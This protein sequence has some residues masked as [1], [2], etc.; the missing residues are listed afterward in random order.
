[1]G[2]DIDPDN[3]ISFYHLLCNDDRYK[4][5]EDLKD[6]RDQETME[7]LKDYLN[8]FVTVQ[9]DLE[10]YE[11]YG[12]T[13]YYDKHR[14]VEAKKNRMVIY[15]SGQWITDDYNNKGERYTFTTSIVVSKHQEKGE[16]G[17][18]PSQNQYTPSPSNFNDESLNEYTVNRPPEEPQQWDSDY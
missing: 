14:F 9:P 4:T 13:K 16:L 18:D 10:P 17:A 2:D 5:I 15:K 6:I 11:P 8:V 7:A 12:Q 1:M 3:G